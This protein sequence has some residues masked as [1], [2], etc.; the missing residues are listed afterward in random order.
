MSASSALQ[1]VRER[2][3]RVAQELALAHHLELARFGAQAF[4]GGLLARHLALPPEHRQRDRH[5]RHRREHRPARQ[6]A[7]TSVAL[8][9]APGGVGK[10]LLGCR[11]APGIA[12]SPQRQ[13]AVRD[14]RPEQVVR[15]AALVPELRRLSELIA[16][17]RAVGILGAPPHQPGPRGQQRFVDDLDLLKALPF[18]ASPLIGRQ[19]AGADQGVEHRLGRSP[20]SAPASRA[21]TDNRS[22]RPRTARVLRC[23]RCGQ[24][25]HDRNPLG[26]DLLQRRFRVL[27]QGARHAADSAVGRPR[28]E[29]LVPVAQVPQSR[30]GESQQRQRAPFVGDLLDHLLDQRLVLE[31]VAARER[32]LH[33]GPTQSAIAE[34]PEDREVPR[35]RGEGLV[36]L[37]VNQ[38]V[39]PQRHDHMRVGLE[40]HP[41][42]QLREAR[43]NSGLILREQFLEL[44]DDYERVLVP[45]APACDGFH[46]GVRVPNR[47]SV[48]DASVSSANW[49]T[50]A[51]A[52][53]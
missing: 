6:P 38:E 52:R 25:P 46:G 16:Q 45:A 18:V 19:Q 33:Q 2:A 20:A 28:Q 17:L 26:A 5:E 22:S 34:R 24:F 44:I 12:L 39:V 48:C 37:A 51:S 47:S 9:S 50:S 32:R 15:L 43:S 35:H 42:E 40:Y 30:R 13:V 1:N 49:G 7:P 29:A 4:G 41:P 10:G 8:H 53:R 36:R 31:V 11:Q 27:R 3:G 23:D 14:A 21:N